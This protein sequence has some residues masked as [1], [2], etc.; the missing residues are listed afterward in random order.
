M[1]YFEI[2]YNFQEIQYL[3]ISIKCYWLV[4]ITD[5]QYND[6]IGS[7][8]TKS[9]KNYNSIKGK[10]SFVVKLNYHLKLH[11]LKDMYRINLWNY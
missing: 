10:N 8:T 9:L 5:N 7:D 2:L 1:L 4:I 6:V 11:S 3:L